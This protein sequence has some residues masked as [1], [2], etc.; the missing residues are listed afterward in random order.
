MSSHYT[1]K[2]LPDR[3]CL[4]PFMGLN[5][6][7]TGEWQLC[8]SARKKYALNSNQKMPFIWKGSILN[9][10]RREML[11]NKKVYPDCT[12]CFH[13]EKAGA[14]SKRIRFNRKRLKIYGN[15]A[16]YESV[17]REQKVL[18]L[19]I[20]F[21][22]LCNLDCVTCNSEYSSSWVKQDYQAVSEG[23]SFRKIRTNKVWKIDKTFI[24]SILDS[25][26]QDMKLIFIKGGEPLIDSNCLYF[27]KKLSQLKKEDLIVYIQ[28][29]G[30][31]MDSKVI[32]AIEGLNI[33]ISFSVDGLNTY[34]DWIRG[35]DF[36][37]MMKNFEK[38][39]TISSLRHSYFNYTVSAFN[40][41]RA[42]DFI[43][44]FME[45]KKRFSRLRRLSFS[46]AHQSYLNFRVFN[47]EVRNKVKQDI[48]S[49]VKEL[50]IKEDLLDG[51]TALGQELSMDSLDDSA[52]Q[53]FKK[54]LSF[55]NSIRKQNL[56]D[57][58]PY[59]DKILKESLS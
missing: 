27:L 52:V 53:K 6:H 48:Q 47:K 43:R 1:K 46:I 18:E 25:S 5:I 58:D 9:S 23:L 8:S 7:P 12:G 11:A 42:P 15:S 13:L 32:S 35:F 36:S 28:T 54:W 39:H 57:I 4:I 20:S 44:F 50:D 21:S 3:L 41:H 59:F 14:D 16:C 22:N 45:Q 37:K 56:W 29:N 17:Y 10:I 51:W 19:D 49:A 34:Y 2:A 33:E 55:C 31:V 40:F 30:T 26:I 24:D 38:M